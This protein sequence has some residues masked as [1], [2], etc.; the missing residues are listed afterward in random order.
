MQDSLAAALWY[1][2]AHD[3]RRYTTQDLGHA[4]NEAAFR[5][6]RATSGLSESA[7]LKRLVDLML[8][9]TDPA[10]YDASTSAD[11][12]AHP[13]NPPDRAAAP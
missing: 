4:R 7:L 9:S 8:R 12:E 13:L 3:E 1:N 2:V 11:P 10:S 6:G 5:G